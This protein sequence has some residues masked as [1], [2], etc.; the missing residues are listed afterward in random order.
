MKI[1]ELMKGRREINK[2]YY[3]TRR[4]GLQADALQ[5]VL[6]NHSQCRDMDIRPNI[7]HNEQAGK[8]AAAGGGNPARTAANERRGVGL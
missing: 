1:D 5:I 4:S 2:K 8:C 6:M 3:S 7:W